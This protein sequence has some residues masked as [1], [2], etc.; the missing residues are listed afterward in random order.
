[1]QQFYHRSCSV[2]RFCC[3]SK[4]FC[5]KKNKHRTHLL[6]FSFYDVVHY[7]I[8]ERNTTFHKRPKPWFKL[9]EFVFYRVFYIANYRQ[10]FG[11][12]FWDKFTDY[13]TSQHETSHDYS[14]VLFCCINASISSIFRAFAERFSGSPS[15]IK[16]SSSILT[17]M[18]HHFGSQSEPSG[19]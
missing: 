16:I 13:C 15:V 2:G 11:K 12:L 9:I 4:N 3:F 5:R 17:P 18:F 10:F 14:S 7:P 1:M 6:A 19:I 8:K